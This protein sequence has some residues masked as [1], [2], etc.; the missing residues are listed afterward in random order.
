MN[1]RYKGVLKALG[2]LAAAVL[3]LMTFAAYRNPHF[4]VQLSNAFWSCF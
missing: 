2:G 1:R 3:L 4:A